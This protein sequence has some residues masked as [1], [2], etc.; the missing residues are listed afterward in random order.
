MQMR[1]QTFNPS[2]YP[3]AG[4]YNFGGNP[5]QQYTIGESLISTYT[6]SINMFSLGFEQPEMNLIIDSIGVAG[7]YSPG[8]Q[9]GIPFT[10]QGIYGP[11]NIFTVQLSNSAGSFSSP[12][13]IGFD[14]AQSSGTALVTMP[15]ISTSTNYRMRIVSSYP[16]FTG[17]P[18]AFMTIDSISRVVYVVPFTSGINQDTLYLADSLTF[19]SPG[20]IYTSSDSVY[21]RYHVI[22]PSNGSE[23]VGVSP[24]K[25]TSD[26]FYVADNLTALTSGNSYKLEF[27]LYNGYR[28]SFTLKKN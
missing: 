19:T 14:T 16:T 10:T 27:L 20:Y 22:D 25:Y 9:I 8:S 15:S 11:G 13:N 26:G 23:V 28:Y 21:F 18:T 4:G 2:V 7:P 3:S 17:G 1:A 6:D 24:V 5:Q 12:T